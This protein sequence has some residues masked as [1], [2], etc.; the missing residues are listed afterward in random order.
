M[1]TAHFNE[2]FAMPKYEKSLSLHVSGSL[3]EAVNT[4]DAFVAATESS[5]FPEQTRREIYPALILHT[6]PEANAAMIEKF[7]TMPSLEEFM[8]A[9]ASLSTNSAAGT[10]G[11][12]IT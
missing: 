10:T 11:L 8:T 12:L 5:V 7:S 3:H 1:V 2:W 6:Y 4:K 9:I